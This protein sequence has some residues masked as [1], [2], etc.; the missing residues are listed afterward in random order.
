MDDGK[1]SLQL[2]ERL[3]GRY[4]DQVGYVVVLN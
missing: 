1:D 4:G 3:L 2:L